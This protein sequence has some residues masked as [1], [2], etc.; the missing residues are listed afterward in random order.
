[1]SADRC[2]QRK[3]RSYARIVRSWGST[4]SHALFLAPSAPLPFFSTGEQLFGELARFAEASQRLPYP[5]AARLLQEAIIA[6]C[7]QP[8]RRRKTYHLPLCDVKLAGTL[9]RENNPEDTMK[10]L[11]PVHAHI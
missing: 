9:L 5:Y 7:G 4:V 10:A 6:R 2:T 3:Q 11:P 8:G 1:M